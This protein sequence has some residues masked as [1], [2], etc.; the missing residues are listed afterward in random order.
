ML[1]YKTPAQIIYDTDNGTSHQQDIAGLRLLGTLQTV[2]E[3]VQ[4]D[5]EILSQHFQESHQIWVDFGKSDYWV[6][7]IKNKPL[8]MTHEAALRIMMRV[9]A[10]H[11]VMLTDMAGWMGTTPADLR[12]HLRTM[13]DEYRH[14]I[15]Q[16][17]N[18]RDDPRKHSWQVTDERYED[19]HVGFGYAECVFIIK[20][21][22]P[23]I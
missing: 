15:A 18:N 23:G 9:S 14:T 6:C 4:I 12:N 21:M 5:R 20:R 8:S 16:Y 22:L 7:E 13:A 17:F 19:K 2:L 3:T 11:T 1:I 10:G